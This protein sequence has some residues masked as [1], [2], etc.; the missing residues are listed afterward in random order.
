MNIMSSARGTNANA[1]HL[2]LQMSWNVESLTLHAHFEQFFFLSADSLLVA[3]PQEAYIIK[4]NPS[5]V[6]WILGYLK[7]NAERSR[8]AAE[9]LVL[10]QFPSP[11][12]LLTAE[13]LLILMLGL[14]VLYARMEIFPLSSASSLWLPLFCLH[15]VAL[16][17]PSVPT[18]S[19]NEPI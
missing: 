18:L 6:W 9:P 7:K 19:Q 3:S 15:S 13:A 12:C 1:S 14:S 16:S 2:Q 5:S 10:N 4:C 11:M 8:L 17:N